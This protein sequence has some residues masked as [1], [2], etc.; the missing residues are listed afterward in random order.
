MQMPDAIRPTRRAIEEIA[1]GMAFARADG[2]IAS[3]NKSGRTWFRFLL[4]NYL[5]AV[6][7][8]GL[9]IDFHNVFAV[10]PNYRLN[11]QQGWRA[12]RFDD[13][14]EVPFIAVTHLPY[15]PRLFRGRDILFVVRDPRDVLVSAYFHKTRHAGL[16]AG[17]IEAFVRSPEHGVMDLVGFLNGWSARIGTH[18][19][20]VI[21]YERLKA[22]PAGHL[23]DVLNFLRLPVERTAVEQALAAS[24]FEAMLA[25]EMKNGHPA[26]RYDRADPDSRRVRRGRIG[27]FRETLQPGLIAEIEETCARHLSAASKRLLR[28]TGFAPA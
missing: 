9:Q 4:A 19:H 27:S 26:H 23:E 2:F 17:Q 10:I 22:D 12:Y 8:L 3:Y 1:L 25:I 11:R 7:D 16:F 24:S 15:R 14:A 5:N 18:R 13:R 28:D 20:Y 6:F 21:A